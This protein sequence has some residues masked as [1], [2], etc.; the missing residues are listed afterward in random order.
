VLGGSLGV[1]LNH[2]RGVQCGVD[3]CEAYLARGDTVGSLRVGI[4]WAF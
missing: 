3:T 2:A 4:G 1:A